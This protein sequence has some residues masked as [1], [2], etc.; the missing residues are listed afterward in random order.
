MRVT[1]PDL[2]VITAQGEENKTFSF[3]GQQLFYSAQQTLFY[4]NDIIES[5]VN[6]NKEDFAQGEYNIEL[7]TEG[8]KLGE[9]KIVLK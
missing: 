1:T 4:D 2:K 3:N 6:L 5:C 8:Y 7:Y 9:A